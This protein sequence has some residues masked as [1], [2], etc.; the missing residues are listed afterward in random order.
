MD[1]EETIKVY[2]SI[3]PSEVCD[4]M[5]EYQRNI[6]NGEIKEKIQNIKFENHK[7][8]TFI[9]DILTYCLDEYINNFKGINIFNYS[10]RRMF[11][12]VY[13][14]G[15]CKKVHCD[16]NRVVTLDLILNDDYDGGELCF[17]EQNLSF[18]PPK[19]SVTIFP[20]NFLFPHE[21]KEV[22]SEIPRTNIVG[23]YEF[24]P[25]D[26]PTIYDIIED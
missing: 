22:K 19:G 9:G 2:E 25:K 18:K 16:T 15:T 8:Y 12:L 17:P 23:H 4:E 24:I 5:F 6:L 14:K 3:V 7:H 26:V 11:L 21:V 20:S 10:L 1:W 13:N